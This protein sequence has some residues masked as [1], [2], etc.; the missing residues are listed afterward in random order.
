MTLASILAILGPITAALAPLF[1]KWV[2]RRWAAKDDPRNQLRSQKDEN[3][4]AIIQT[5]ADELNTLL[6][7][8]I[9]RVQPVKAKDPG[10]VR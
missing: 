5:D 1:A 7:D 3:A 10:P 8:R 2:L 4:Q 9:N 6:D